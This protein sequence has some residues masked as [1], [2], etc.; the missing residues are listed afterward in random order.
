[1][2][3]WYKLVG[4]PTGEAAVDVTSGPYGQALAIPLNCMIMSFLF[5]LMSYSVFKLTKNQG[6]N[7]K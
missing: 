3:H 6:Y 7:Y 5:Y 1:M 2:Q 4:W